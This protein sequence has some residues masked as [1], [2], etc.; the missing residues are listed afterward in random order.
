MKAKKLVT[1]AVPFMLLVGCG[2]DKTEAKPKEK[3]ESK[4]ETKEKLSKEKYPTRMTNL[5]SELVQKITVIT[6]LAMDKDKDEKSLVKEIVKEESEVQKSIA[7]FKKI[8]P[9]K[10]FEDSHK[11]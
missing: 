6:E 4:E 5:S 8:E 1:L 10:E 11:E 7:K 9:P 3:V 2:T